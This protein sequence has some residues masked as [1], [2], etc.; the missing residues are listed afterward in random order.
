VLRR[1]AWLVLIVRFA[2]VFTYT[3][4]HDGHATVVPRVVVGVGAVLLLVPLVRLMREVPGRTLRSVLRK[5]QVL[6][7]RIKQLTAGVVFGLLTALFGALTVPAVLASVLVFSLPVVA[8][9]G[10][11]ANERLW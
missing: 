8:V 3:L 4:A 1:W 10:H 7:V 5:Q 6:A 11:F 9:V 2:V